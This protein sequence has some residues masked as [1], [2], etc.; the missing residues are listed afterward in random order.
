MGRDYYDEIGSWAGPMTRF[1]HGF[2]PMNTCRNGSWSL[3]CMT[4]C[5]NELPEVL[6]NWSPKLR[7]MAY[8]KLK[9]MIHSVF[10]YFVEIEDDHA[11]N[12]FMYSW[13]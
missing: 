6:M 5:D 8:T 4:K 10:I 2:Y 12:R 7:S 11:L 3:S 13:H 9:N 1:A